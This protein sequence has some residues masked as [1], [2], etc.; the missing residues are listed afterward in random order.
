MSNESYV[1]DITWGK[2]FLPRLVGP[3]DSAGEATEWADLNAVG[4]V[5]VVHPLAYPY[6][7]SGGGSSFRIDPNKSSNPQGG[8]DAGI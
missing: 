4:A 6:L 1:L 3:F 2:P 7:R 5:Y 8:N